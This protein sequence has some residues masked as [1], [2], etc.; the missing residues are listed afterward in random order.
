MEFAISLDAKR[1]M[2]RISGTA[3][4]SEK[5]QMLAALV[6]ESTKAGLTHAL[7]LCSSPLDSV[8]IL[9]LMND[10][11]AIGFPANYKFA[12]LVS[13]EKTRET[14]DFAETAA[15]NRGWQLKSFTDRAQAIAWL[16]R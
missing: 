5:R 13:D 6:Q 3:T 16:D 15:V 11:G 8:S 10:L 1:V 9:A 4:E 2:V 12:V 7:L 14:A